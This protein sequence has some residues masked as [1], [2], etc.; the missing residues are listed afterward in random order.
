MKRVTPHELLTNFIKNLNERFKV[1]KERNNAIYHNIDARFLR[2]TEAERTSITNELLGIISGIENLFQGQANVMTPGMRNELLKFEIEAKLAFLSR[3]YFDSHQQVTVFQ[4]EPCLSMLTSFFTRFINAGSWFNCR[5]DEQC[6]R[7]LFTLY[8]FLSGTQQ[9]KV[10]VVRVLNVLKDKCD[11]NFIKLMTIFFLMVETISFGLKTGSPVRQLVAPFERLFEQT[12]HSYHTDQTRLG[13]AASLRD[14]LELATAH[15][16]AYRYL[17]MGFDVNRKQ[18]NPSPPRFAREG[19][20]FTGRVMVRPGI[21][22]E[23]DRNDILKFVKKETEL[24]SAHL[25]PALKLFPSEHYPEIYAQDYLSALTY[26]LLIDGLDHLVDWRGAFVNMLKNQSKGKFS[27]KE[28]KLLADYTTSLTSDVDSWQKQVTFIS[29]YTIG[30]N[31]E[32]IANKSDEKKDLA[33]LIQTVKT[34]DE[35]VETNTDDATKVVKKELDKFAALEKAAAKAGGVLLAWEDARKA[36][37]DRI[38]QKREA[39]RAAAEATKQGSPFIPFF[40]AIDGNADKEE[41]NVVV[42]P[43]TEK[44]DCLKR[45]EFHD[46]KLSECLMRLMKATNFISRVMKNRMSDDKPIPFE[47]MDL[48]KV[49]FNSTLSDFESLKGMRQKFSALAS[50]LPPEEF[51]ELNDGITESLLQAKE[52]EAY[53]EASLAQTSELLTLK[54]EKRERE[55]K[56]FIDGL[57][58]EIAESHY[59][60]D[61]LT[62]EQRYELGYAEFVRRGRANVKNGLGA[63]SD[64][65]L[66]RKY[67]KGFKTI[68]N[69]KLQ[70]IAK[71]E[72][73]LENVSKPTLHFA[74]PERIQAKWELIRGIPGDHFLFGNTLIDLLRGDSTTSRLGLASTIDFALTCGTIGEVLDAQNR[75]HVS[76][77]NVKQGRLNVSSYETV[78]VFLT[79]AYTQQRNL[80]P[81]FFT[82]DGVVA[83]ESGQ[84]YELI[85]TGLK[86]IKEGTLR[87]AQDPVAT[88]KEHPQAVL[89][90]VFRMSKGFVPDLSLYNALFAWQPLDDLDIDYMKAITAE[91]LKQLAPDDREDYVSNWNLL[92]L[93]QKIFKTEMTLRELER[94]VLPPPPPLP[95]FPAKQD[96]PQAVVDASPQSKQSRDRKGASGQ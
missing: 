89:V 4:S 58:A 70:T 53:F 24:R 93:S 18:K 47:T 55:K 33:Y 35:T 42:S 72:A 16:S 22:I 92:G 60:D 40:Q 62:P 84:I 7:D 77:Y 65:A 49:K 54:R 87:T 50:S 34:R 51:N 1:V 94:L 59:P 30:D 13:K 75:F 15:F 11:A 67:L 8:S 74:Y 86:D 52:K 79:G 12:F 90:A 41:K 96:T 83:D 37:Y 2:A 45:L 19:I 44:S 25:T 56:E 64:K 5:G 71:K 43:A 46:A 32:R 78:N 6:Q 85:E 29:S 80:P 39:A 31:A 48:L 21:G 23:N 17:L 26:S 9:D 66:E 28:N 38:K 81:L 36:R 69:Q 14:K 95:F 57:G 27:V 10:I 88:L 3:K 61:N 20:G 63:M 82:C 76:K 73:P 91:H 68:Y